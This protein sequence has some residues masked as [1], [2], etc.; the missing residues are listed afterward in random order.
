MSLP[1]AYAYNFGAPFNDPD[2]DLILRSTPCVP[3]GKFCSAPTHFCV[4]K[5][6]LIKASPVFERLLRETASSEELNPDKE[7]GITHDTFDN[8]PVLCL[9]V[10]RDTLH[11]LLTAIYPTDVAYPRTLEAMMKTYSAARKHGLSSTLALF[12]TYCN[13]IARIVTTENAFRAYLFAFSEGLKEEA[14]EA[15]RLTLSLPQTFETYGKDLCNASGPALQALW[16]HRQVALKAIEKGVQECVQEVGDLRGWKSSS[17][18]DKSCCAV[19]GSRPREQFLIF[20]RKLTMDFSLMN[21]SC[22]IDAMSSQGGF[23]CQSCKATQRLDYLRLFNCL[24]RH[25]CGHIEQV[26]RSNLLR[27]FFPQTLGC[28]G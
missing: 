12:R 27:G 21:F 13:G 15:A 17:P 28:H 19:P 1:F 16:R 3:P 14:L 26:S 5:L 22:F 24:E 6:F 7:T 9:S 25:V 20:T 11:S 8:L 4:H 23:K 18:F 2:A 10:D